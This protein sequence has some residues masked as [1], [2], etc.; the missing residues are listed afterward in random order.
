MRQIKDEKELIGKTI[1]G[2]KTSW[3]DTD[4]LVIFFGDEYAVY[5][6]YSSIDFSS[7]DLSNFD[8]RDTGIIS[9]E[10]YQAIL[11]EAERVKQ[12]EAEEKERAQLE[13][14]TKKYRPRPK[15][16][17]KKTKT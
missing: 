13:Y 9:K 11:A 1:T 6:S 12:E 17:R 4:K 2:V 7:V 15:V 16:N 10:E 14:L 3:D 8:K 5:E